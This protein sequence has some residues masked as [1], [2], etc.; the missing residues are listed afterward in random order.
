MK[1]E[2]R[3]KKNQE[4]KANS[5]WSPKSKVECL[6]GLIYEVRN[7]KIEGRSLKEEVKKA[8]SLKLKANGVQSQKHGLTE[9]GVEMFDLRGT[10]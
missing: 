3:S 5:R 8:N 7:T 1:F 6:K 9:V 2:G 10:K 4:P